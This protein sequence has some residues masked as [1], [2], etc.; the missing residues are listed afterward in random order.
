MRFH[1]RWA[2]EII[3]AALLCASARANGQEMRVLV[4]NTAKVSDG[5]VAQA[6]RETVRIFRAAGVQLAWVNCSGR[7]QSAGCVV[8]Q[9]S[10][11]LVLHIIPK[12]KVSTDSVYGEAFLAADGAGKYADIFYDRIEGAKR[13]FG[14]SPSLLLGAVSAHEIGHLL[15]GLR[16][17][18]WIGVMAPVWRKESFQSL[19]MGQL[20]FT[21][22]QAAQLRER[23]E[24]NASQITNHLSRKGTRLEGWNGN[25]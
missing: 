13:D 12:G 15:L 1:T 22:D 2:G 25:P 9:Q 17:H 4:Y 5:I 3:V 7:G 21:R 11:E 14:V 18:S 16:A 10:P 19:Q 8:Q 20:F 24:E 23:S 6:G